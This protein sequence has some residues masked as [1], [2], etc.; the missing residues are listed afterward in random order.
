MADTDLIN[1]LSAALN[2]AFFFFFF[3][4]FTISI[5]SHQLVLYASMTL[6]GTL[7]YG[8]RAIAVCIDLISQMLRV[9]Y[10]NI[11]DFVC[12]RP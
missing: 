4:F 2:Q 5:L 11:N 3:F 9:P 7:D 10:R 8:V 12:D 6:N 1:T